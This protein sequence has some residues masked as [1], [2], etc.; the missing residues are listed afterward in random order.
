MFGTDKALKIC[1]IGHCAKNS[2]FS[3]NLQIPEDKGNCAILAFM[4]QVN[5]LLA[6]MKAINIRCWMCV[7]LL[8]NHTKLMVNLIKYNLQQDIFS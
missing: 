8:E 4:C 5:N 7:Y 3:F 2:K 1:N 6:E